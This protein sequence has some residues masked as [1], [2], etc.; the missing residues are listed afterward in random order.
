MKAQKINIQWE[1][2][3]NL[4]NHKCTS[5]FDF[6]PEALVKRLVS[7]KKI[8]KSSAVYNLISWILKNAFQVL[9]VELTYMYNACIESCIFPKSWNIGKISPI[10]KPAKNSSNAKDWRPITQIP[11]PGKLLERILHD[12]IY[13]YFE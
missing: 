13:K 2:S 7:E 8:S 9:T 1:A 12:Q 5:E 10:P 11:L 3:E 6:I 4:K